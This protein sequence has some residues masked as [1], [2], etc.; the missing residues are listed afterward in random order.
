MWP[1]LGA[2]LEPIPTKF[3]SAEL[4]PCGWLSNILKTLS[5]CQVLW[6]PMLLRIMQKKWK[7]GHDILHCFFPCCLSQVEEDGR[8]FFMAFL[9]CM[10]HFFKQNICYWK[11]NFCWL[12]LFWFDCSGFVVLKLVSDRQ[13]SPRLYKN[14]HRFESI[15]VIWN[16]ACI[17]GTYNYWQNLTPE[18]T[19]W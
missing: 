15:W 6:M 10:N 11:D 17:C 12:H 18:W 14:K 8:M 19:T 2:L 5:Q 4:S 9:F 13:S 3:T 1:Y 16:E 7:T